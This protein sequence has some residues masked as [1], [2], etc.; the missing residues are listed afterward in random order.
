ME[1]EA[2]QHLSADATRVY[3]FMRKRYN[4]ANNGCVIFS[5]RDAMAALRSGC[6]RAGKALRELRTKGFVKLRAPGKPGP[7][8]RPAGEWQLTAFECG[9]QPASKDFVRWR[10]EQLPTPETGTPRTQ[11]RCGYSDIEVRPDAENSRKRT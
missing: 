4:G 3:L 6:D 2:F 7:N 10:P 11:N 5:W 8:I 1:T 9:G